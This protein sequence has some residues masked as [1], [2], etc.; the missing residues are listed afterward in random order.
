MKTARSTPRSV[1]Q[2]VQDAELAVTREVNLSG[3]KPKA[4]P[5]ALLTTSPHMNDPF[6][7][8]NLLGYEELEDLEELRRESARLEQQYEEEKK[9][10]ELASNYQHA[11]E[12]E[13]EQLSAQNLMPYT[14][15]ELRQELERLQRIQVRVLPE[16]DPSEPNPFEEKTWGS[17]TIRRWH[18]P[19][20]QRYK[21]KRTVSNRNLYRD[22][23]EK[24][25][26]TE[27][28]QRMEDT[29]AEP[30]KGVR[31]GYSDS[32][33]RLHLHNQPEDR[34]QEESKDEPALTV[35]GLRVTADLKKGDS[36]SE[37]SENA[38]PLPSEINT[39]SWL[40]KMLDLVDSIQ[41]T[42]EI[43]V[44]KCPHRREKLFRQAVRLREEIKGYKRFE[45]TNWQLDMRNM[46][47]NFT[48]T[49]ITDF[50]AQV[51]LESK[52]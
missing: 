36:E 50:Q 5:K 49:S 17:P 14:P 27:Q 12:I 3:L 37:S 26:M 22:E 21:V 44:T 35:A 51:K 39:P 32:T 38:D 8:E 46:V 19:R 20:P 18:A 47:H 42:I 11:L 33:G 23:Q 28:D 4:L 48:M 43:R 45:R 52:N 15:R 24:I 1:E 29:K 9:K 25:K 10:L 13:N 31:Y 2:L 41:E 16:P 7:N 34:A 6:E 40:S 30:R